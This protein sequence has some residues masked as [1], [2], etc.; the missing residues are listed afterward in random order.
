MPTMIFVNLAVDDVARSRA[1]FEAL[2]YSINEGFSDENAV[3]VVI[4]DTITAMLLTRPFFAEFTRKTII[5]ATTSTEV[6]LALS[7]ESKEEVDATYAAALAA[8]ATPAGEQDHGFMYSKSF[9]DLDGHHWDFVWMDPAA[10]AGGAPELSVD[11]MRAG[12]TVA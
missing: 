3:S 1:F 5:D 6:Q 4:S 8:G 10:A 9:D 2:G 7:A 11:E 12:T